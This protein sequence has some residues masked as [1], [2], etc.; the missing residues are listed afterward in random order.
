MADEEEVK[1]LTEDLSIEYSEVIKE[2]AIEPST[3]SGERVYL[4]GNLH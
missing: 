2:I 4:S 1:P 3:V